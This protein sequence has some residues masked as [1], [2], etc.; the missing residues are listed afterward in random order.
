MSASLN[1]SR[2]SV[3]LIDDEASLLS[4]LERV[5]SAA[6]YNVQCAENGQRGLDRFSERSWDAVIMDRAMPEM[7]GE[8]VAQVIKATAPNLPLV[9]M[10]GFPS[11]VMRP[12]L[13]ET[14]LRKPFRPAELLSSLDSAWQKRAA[15][16]SAA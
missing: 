9:M 6:G 10:T 7:N 4:I 3:L 12:E 16:L 1:N 13:F 8:E 5:L 14:I 11:A 15:T 2:K